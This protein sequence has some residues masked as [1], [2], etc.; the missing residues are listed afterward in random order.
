MAHAELSRAPE[1]HQNKRMNLTHLKFENRSNTA[2]SRFLQSFAFLIKL[3]NS[4]SSKGNFGGNQ[5]QDGPSF[6][7]P[8][9]KHNERFV[10][11]YR[12]KSPTSS[13]LT[14]P[15]SRCVHHRSTPNT[16][17]TQTNFKIT[18]CTQTHIQTHINTHI[19]YTHIDTHVHT[20]V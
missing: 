14:L 15:F 16:C 11:Q 13:F 19:H 6:F 8:L 9:S 2:R 18:E 1:V 10:R 3:F 17:L 12:H 20:Y 4:S 7:A 5:L